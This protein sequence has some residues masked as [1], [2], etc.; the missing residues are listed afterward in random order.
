MIVCSGAEARRVVSPWRV[1]HAAHEAAGRG[2]VR[3]GVVWQALVARQARGVVRAGSWMGI[4]LRE[5]VLRRSIA[6][7][8]R[9]TEELKKRGG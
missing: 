2:P 9:R 3:F 7:A 8:R 5:V 1:T 6:W 4:S